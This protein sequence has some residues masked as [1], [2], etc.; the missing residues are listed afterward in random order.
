MNPGDADKPASRLAR[1][2]QKLER[3]ARPFRQQAVSLV[4]DAQHR[5][6]GVGLDT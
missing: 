5:L 6:Y 2:I 3:M 1:T 4:G